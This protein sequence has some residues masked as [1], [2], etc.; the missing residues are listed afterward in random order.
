[1]KGNKYL[2]ISVILGFILGWALGFLR[3]PLL[4]E[5]YSFWVGLISCLALISFIVVALFIWNKNKLLNNLIGKSSTSS[6]VGTMNKTYI[7]IWAFISLFIVLGGTLSGILIYKQ[8]QVF[9]THTQFLNEKIEE[10][11]ISMKAIKNNNLVLRMRIFL[12]DIDL[13][14][15]S[16]SKDSLSDETITKIADF[17]K[18]DL[19]GANLMKV[20]FSNTN[21]T[22]A[23]LERVNIELEW[24][25][26]LDKW[27]I[28]G[29]KD[30]KSL[31]RVR[32]D[33]SRPNKL[34]KFRLEKVQQ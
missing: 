26:K 9:K 7:T 10:Q 1:M 12:D 32:P 18:C 21:L 8:N 17:T 23:N 25:E 13:E 29:E 27:Q 34:A 31:Y 6:G 28:I 3:I 19:L 24:L 14:L 33:K 11:A 15:K 5:N 2:L 22:E 4:E 30:I 16:N 20:N